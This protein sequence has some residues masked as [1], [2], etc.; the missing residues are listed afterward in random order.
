M[1]RFG[2][3]SGGSPYW[4][5]DGGRWRRPFLVASA[6]GAA[7]SGVV[8]VLSFLP[9]S[10][11]VPTA[12]WGVLFAGV[13]VVHVRS[14]LVLRRAQ[15]RRG[16]VQLSAWSLQARLERNRWIW[17]VAAL[18]IVSFV[19]AFPTLRG[20]PEID[21][22]HYFLNDHGSLIPVSRDAYLRALAAQQRLFTSV[23]AVFYSLGVMAN[24]RDAPERPAANC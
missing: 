17:L 12:V 11:P 2:D 18:A 5:I 24:R 4:G 10:P 6:V 1:V 7:A 21:H 22:G 16:Q 20:Q 15:S 3:I 8:V 9:F 19:T 14:V 23:A 13:L